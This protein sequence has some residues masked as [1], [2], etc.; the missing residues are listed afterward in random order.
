M[1]PESV[2]REVL[3]RDNNHCVAPTVDD[4]AGQCHDL[5]GRSGFRVPIAHLELDHVGEMRTGKA[6]KSI[7]SKLVTL[8]PGHH[9]G[10][11]EKA[12][13]VWATS[14]RPELR[15]YLMAHEPSARLGAGE[16]LS[17]VELS[18]TAYSRQREVL[19]ANL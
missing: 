8:C 16:Q 2:R 5:Y 14:H 1:I 18:W 11:G 13:R 10:I 3:A 12:G 7:P 19:D 17:T 6:A 15:A 4:T 9:R